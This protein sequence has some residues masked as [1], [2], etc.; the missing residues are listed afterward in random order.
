MFQAFGR[1]LLAGTPI[2]TAIEKWRAHILRF[3]PR[4]QEHYM[5]VLR[6]FRQFL[7]VAALE[8]LRPRHIEGYINHLLAKG[9]K[10]RTINA[11]L[12][13]LKSFCGW[14]ARNY[15]IPNI[16]IG[17]DML[18]EDPPRQRVLSL[19]EYQKVLAVCEPH[20]ADMIKFLAHT[21][22]RATEAVMLTWRDINPA[23]TKIILTGK[24][25]RRR[26]VPLNKTCREILQK[27]PRT[28]ETH[29]DFLKSN[30]RH[31]NYICCKLATKA[32]IRPFGPH[33]LRHFFVTQMIVE[34]KVP[35]PIVSQIVGHSSSRTTE[36]I[37]LH[38]L[39]SDLLHTTDVLD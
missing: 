6:Q 31:L 15:D 25:R 3:T 32:H 17:F 13:A 16:G 12:T 34:H 33:S 35:L 24:G 37:Y 19:T 7:D 2:I 27:Y 29:I 10:N 21:G 5:M 4:T 28:P 36:K 14:L 23:L 26:I 8:D 30:R 1:K 39:E 38:I 22:L 20:E 9:V 11:H 18:P